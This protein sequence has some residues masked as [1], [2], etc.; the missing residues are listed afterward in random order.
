[1][2][3][4]WLRLS[5]NGLLRS[6]RDSGVTTPGYIPETE[7]SIIECYR[8]MRLPV[9]PVVALVDMFESAVS[10]AKEVR[11]RGAVD[12]FISTMEEI[13]V[14]TTSHDSLLYI[15]N[16]CYRLGHHSHITRLPSSTLRLGTQGSNRSYL[17]SLQSTPPRRK[18]A[19]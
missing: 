11:E 1:M 9:V 10:R 15:A 4:P 19:S 14:R 6:R 13:N 17:W 7:A 3:W 12:E 16:E 8:K 18:P 5:V 2:S